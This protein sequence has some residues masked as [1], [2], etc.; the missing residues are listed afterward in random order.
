MSDS[1]Q[2]PASDIAPPDEP[3]R[4]HRELSH[5]EKWTRYERYPYMLAKLAFFG[6]LAAILYWLVQSVESIVFPI[7][8]SMLVAWLFDPYIDRIEERGI[9]RTVGILLLLFALTLFLVGFSAILYPMIA[10]QVLLIGEKI[11][12]LVELVQEDLLPWMQTRFDWEMPP[13]LSEAVSRY[14]TELKEAAPSVLQKVGSWLGKAVTQTG[15][16]VNSL[17]NLVMIPIF[18]FYFLRDFDKMRLSAAR[19]LPA[20]NR[21]L[22]TD[23]LAKIDEVVGA[24]FRGQVQVAIILSILYSL[25]LVV[26]F[27][28]TDHDI[29]SGIAIGILAGL[30]NIIPYFGFIIGFGLS[31]IVTLID[32]HGLWGLGGVIITFTVVQTLE[33]YVITPRV[34]GEKVGLSPVTVIVVLLVGGEIGG[35]LG[36]LL[37]IP[38]AGAIKVLLPDLIDYYESSTYFTGE[39]IHPPASLAAETTDDVEPSTTYESQGADRATTSSHEADASALGA[40]ADLAT[41]GPETDD[42]DTVV[43]TESHDDEAADGELEAEESEIDEEESVE[44][45]TR[46]GEGEEE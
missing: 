31:I 23:R 28:I 38:A 21:E 25:G 8:I 24:W 42:E 27:S 5:A 2:A 19:Y 6:A 44:G 3:V 35:L 20:F 45:S 43:A 9:N 11:P 32:W 4:P 13:T 39:P 15:V 36:V 7:F 40:T 33:G 37:A 22:I 34:V 12:Q 16:I 30:L 17:L 1:Q 18:S 41:P 29:E 14:G 10:S 46:R 26:T